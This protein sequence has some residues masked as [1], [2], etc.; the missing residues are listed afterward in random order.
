MC[1][2][3]KC[4]LDLIRRIAKDNIPVTKIVIVCDNNRIFS[5]I[6]Q[7]EYKIDVLYK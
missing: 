7:F 1:W 6:K 3:A 2:V 4:K 5:Y